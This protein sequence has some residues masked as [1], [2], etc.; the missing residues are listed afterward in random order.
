MTSTEVT[1]DQ[2]LDMVYRLRPADQARLF[3]RLAPIVEQLLA[4]LPTSASAARP[5]L[6]GL[7]ADLGP[8]PS[9][10]DIAEV[11]QEMWA[12]RSGDGV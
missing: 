7:L 4:E 10:A 2:V 11:Q 1:L 3:V 9:D 5:P 6:R 8:A 12:N